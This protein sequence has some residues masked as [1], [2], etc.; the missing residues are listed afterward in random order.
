MSF[1]APA[2]FAALA[3]ALPILL[4]YM[5]RLRRREVLISSTFLWRQVVQDTEAN[6]P[7]QRLRRNLLLFLQLLILLLLVLALTRPFI[8][9]PAISAGKIAL[10]ID[11][12]ASMTAVDVAGET[13]FSA[14][15][16]KA[17]QI[18]NNMNP[19]DVISLIRVAEV[20]EP[21]TAYTADK[22]ELRRALDGMIVSQGAGDWDTALTLAAAGAAGA[23]NFSIV[24]ISDGGLGAAASLPSNIPGPIY[25]PVGESANNVA[26]TALATRSLAGGEPQLFAQVTNYGDQPADVSLVIALDDVLRL[27]R[28]G[29][30]PP[31]SQLPI[32]FAEPIAEPFE[33]LSATL[34]FDNDV[35]D[36]LALDNRAWTVQNQVKTRRVY[37]V[38]GTGNLFLEQALR[39]LPG[40]QTFRGNA[41]NLALPAAEFDLYVFDNWLSNELPAGDMLLINPPNSTPLFGLGAAQGP[42]DEFLVSAEESP[43]TAFVDLDEMS[44]L[45]YRAVSADWAQP[46]INAPDGP[47]LLAGEINAQQIA[48][49]PF[50]LRD[51]N[52]PLLIAWPVL[53]ANLLDWFSPADIVPL[54]D[55]LGVGD[56][57][58][59]SPPLLADSLRITLPDGI[60]REL[61]IEG[62]SLAFTETGQL[63]L[64]R[65]E[66]LQAGEVMQ[67]QSFA[68][69]IFG[70]GESDIRPL[71]E[72]D[73][74]LKLGGGAATVA[75]DEKLGLQEFWMLL[76]AAALLLLVIEWIVYHRRLQVPTLLRPA[77]SRFNWP[78]GRFR[79]SSA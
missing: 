57:L 51:S 9:V 55:G 1:L 70:A 78:W 61:P 45:G 25:V 65:L 52:L 2:A 37:Y 32:P 24:M 79:N 43:I 12:S 59:I 42:A 5:L 74:K 60:I 72:A 56:V 30:I 58:S 28:S 75:E 76:A 64:Y 10:L 20:A 3:I 40:V 69:N 36:F 11:A 44:L 27:S 47:V 19:Q 38:S 62:E 7:W 39:S 73:L 8:T 23:E 4:L 41:E 29:R 34:T 13:R 63:G 18:V 31:R 49:L 53:M 50:D 16:D 71:A 66:V 14:A 21:L 26:I 35:D 48:I 33:T 17:H 68:V 77:P 54:P 15:I 67:A 6:T 46:L 22:N